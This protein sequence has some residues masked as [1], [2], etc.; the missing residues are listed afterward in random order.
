MYVLSQNLDKN[1]WKY[2]QIVC[3]YVPYSNYF[4]WHIP[5]FGTGIPLCGVL[6]SIFASNYSAFD[7]NAHIVNLPGLIV[8]TLVPYETKK[9][10]GQQHES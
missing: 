8:L 2:I 10:V 3:Q 1:M 5:N 9:E 4:L 7:S 6:I